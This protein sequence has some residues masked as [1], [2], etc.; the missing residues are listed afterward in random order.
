MMPEYA[1]SKR[2]LF[3]AEKIPL[4]GA[5]YRVL[6]CEGVNPKRFLPEAL[7]ELQAPRGVLGV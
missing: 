6:Q 1:K 3:S 5:V 2:S 4:P 7:L